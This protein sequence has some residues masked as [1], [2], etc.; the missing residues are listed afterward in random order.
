MKTLF[1]PLIKK[2]QLNKPALQAAIDKLPSTI[3]IA[4]TI[5]YKQIAEQAKAELEK[6]R[7]II[8]F[9]Q[10]LGCSKL[11]V[12]SILLIADGSFHAS[13]LLQQGNQVYLFDNHSLIKLELQDNNNK[14]KLNKLY[15]SNK[16]GILLST[17][18]GQLNLN[19]ARKTKNKL[20]EQNK[21]AYFFLADNINLDEL[22]NFDVDFWINT[23]CPGLEKDSKNILN[24]TKI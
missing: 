5:Q 3:Y 16:L 13:N 6:T 17:K 8:G 12:N 19:Q 2:E 9:S 10:V 1:I 20:K 23:A 21:K 22:E 18:P 4:Y 11:K 24:A 14:A 7:E 15:S